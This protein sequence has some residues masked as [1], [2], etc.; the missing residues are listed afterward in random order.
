MNTETKP[1]Q[2]AKRQKK[3]VK[4]TQKQIEE[5]V[6]AIKCYIADKPGVSRYELHKRFCKEF[7]VEW[8]TIDRYLD[9][10]R[11]MIQ[12]QSNRSKE[13]FRANA[14]IFYEK[15]IA[16]P[17]A[18]FTEKLRAEMLLTQ[19]VG[20]DAPSRVELTGREGAPLQ[21]ETEQSVELMLK[22]LSTEDIRKAVERMDAQDAGSEAA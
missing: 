15:V 3:Y 5:R 6:N 7:N 22:S 18:R 12:K 16:D 13:E 2:S 19:L 9:R 11:E 17:K 8:P 14:I 1:P 4:P 20:C 10:A 21:L